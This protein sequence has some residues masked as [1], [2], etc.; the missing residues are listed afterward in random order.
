M[1]VKN[2]EFEPVGKGTTF[3]C[4]VT[5]PG[6]GAQLAPE[7]G[8]R[9]RREVF[10]S[11]FKPRRQSLK[12]RACVAGSFCTR[13]ISRAVLAQ[14]AQHQNT[15]NRES[16]HGGQRS[17][18]HESCVAVKNVGKERSHREQHPNSVEP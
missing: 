18:Q 1:R 3:S 17:H 2:I 7:V 10:S 6:M 14:R 5:S 15:A 11:L 4:G 16:H 12:S 13:C 8:L 9:P